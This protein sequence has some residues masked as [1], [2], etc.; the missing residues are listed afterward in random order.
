MSDIKIEFTQQLSDTTRQK[1][2]EGLLSYEKS[3]GVNVDWQP[4]ALELFDEQGEVIGVLESFSS[5][6]CIHIQD[7]WIDENH[8]GKGYG[9]QLIAALEKHAISKGSHNIN[10]VSCDFQAPEFYKKCGFEVEF[11]RKNR[12]NPKLNMTFFVKILV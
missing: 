10:T 9:R 5:Y 1:M 6:S 2:S 7:L 11:I 8:R 4:F 3:H 12:E